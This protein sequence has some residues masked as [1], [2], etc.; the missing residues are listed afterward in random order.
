MLKQRGRPP[1]Q[2][3]WIH[4]A[5]VNGKPTKTYTCWQSLKGK[6]Y[7][8]NDCRWKYYGARGIKVCDRWLDKRQGYDN[9]VMD[10]GVPI[11]DYWIE[12]K[13]NNGDYT[14]DNCCWATPAE[15]ASNRRPGG[16]KPD[17]ASLKQ[18]AKAAGLPYMVVYLR[19]RNLGWTEDRAL[20]TPKGRQGRPARP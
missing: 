6:C 7:N 14:P 18:R 16:P 3:K 20:S 5:R 4:P 2:F 11:G 17:P 9:F 1:G 10:M 8:R 19:I 12:R 13:D 15:Q